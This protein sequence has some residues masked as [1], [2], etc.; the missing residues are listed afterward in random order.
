MQTNTS[1]CKDVMIYCTGI[2]EIKDQGLWRTLEDPGTLKAQDPRRNRSLQDPEP[3][4]L[5]DPG[6]KRT[7]NDEDL[8][9]MAMIIH[10][11]N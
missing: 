6:P 9:P 7:N 2:P 1:S 4:T 3:R 11:K 8:G 5:E 10:S